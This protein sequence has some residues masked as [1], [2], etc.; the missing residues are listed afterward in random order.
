MVGIMPNMRHSLDWADKLMLK[1]FEIV[2]SHTIEPFALSESL[3]MNYDLAE[4]KDF[5]SLYST[6]RKKSHA[7]KILANFFKVYESLSFEDLVRLTQSTKIK[8]SIWIVLKQRIER[9]RSL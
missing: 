3:L 8:R 4:G 2:P 6:S 1:F 5:V 9:L 7:K